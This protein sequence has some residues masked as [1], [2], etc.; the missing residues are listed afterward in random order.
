MALTFSRSARRYA[1]DPEEPKEKGK[2]TKIGNMGIKGIKIVDAKIA[3]DASEKFGTEYFMDKDGLQYQKYIPAYE[4][5]KG[6]IPDFTKSASERYKL[7]PQYTE[8]IKKHG[9][10]K[11]MINLPREQKDMILRDIDKNNISLNGVE[12]NREG[13]FK[14]LNPK[15]YADLTSAKKAGQFEAGQF[16]EDINMLEGV[17]EDAMNLVDYE[18][19]DMS[20]D[21]FYKPQKPVT[22]I[23]KPG[24]QIIDTSGGL[25]IKPPGNL[26]T[27]VTNIRQPAFQNIKDKRAGRMFAQHKDQ[28]IDKSV[29]INPSQ[30]MLPRHELYRTG[31]DL[32]AFNT[33]QLPS[34]TEGMLKNVWK[35]ERFSATAAESILPAATEAAGST[36]ANVAATDLATT[37]GGEVAAAGLVEAGAAQA[38]GALASS[39]A[40][41][42]MVMGVFSG[43]KLL[44]ELFG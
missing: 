9:I 25:S 22:D 5:T 2:I 33:S 27:T 10:T 26:D 14:E 24:E 37:A 11:D 30:N 21:T 32:P 38:G 6:I 16:Q 28:I 34:P 35:P 29:G 7:S 4:D 43:L 31:T 44:D 13:L 8:H 1:Q 42:P 20:L 23:V 19:P 15:E 40:A 41:V 17:S 12:M 36:L 18:S 3:K 39:M